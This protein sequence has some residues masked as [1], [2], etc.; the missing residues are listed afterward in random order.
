MPLAWRVLAQGA[1]FYQNYGM[2]YLVSFLSSQRLLRW[3]V[4]HSFSYE[5]L[6]KFLCCCLLLLTACSS[7]G[8]DQEKRE[9]AQPSFD[10]P[11]HLVY[12][13]QV[14]P[15]GGVLPTKSEIWTISIDGT[16]ARRLTHGFEDSLPR[17]SPDGKQIVFVRES[18]LWLMNA[19]GSNLRRVS[20][21]KAAFL[22]GAEFS[23]DGKSLFFVRPVRL[24]DNDAALQAD[25]FAAFGFGDVAVQFDLPSGKETVLLNEDYYAR[26]I[27]PDPA[28]DGSVYVVCKTLDNQGKPQFGL[29]NVVAKLSL[30]D[31]TPRLFFAPDKSYSL[32]GLRASV[33]NLVL[34]LSPH[35]KIGNEY[36]LLEK[37]VLQKIEKLGFVGDV[38][39]AGFSLAGTVVNDKLQMQLALFD[40]QTQ[41]I[42]LVNKK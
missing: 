36:F 4:W 15:P 12:V 9:P 10:L 33:T 22:H 38:D 2:A 24:D 42:I 17:F 28:D 1:A 5:L 11:G 37:G 3:V 8:A 23:N 27:V 16:N 25:P 31:K 41:T 6:C 7:H 18:Q 14:T 21:T 20:D 32:T 19:D 13:E 40:I 29:E 26:Q 35:N 39:L 34:A 30:K